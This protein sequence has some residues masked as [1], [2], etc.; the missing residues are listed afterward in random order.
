MLAKQNVSTLYNCHLS[1]LLTP[2]DEGP[3]VKGQRIR[4]QDIIDGEY[5]PKKLN[6]SWIGPDEFLYQNHWGEI[7]LLNMN[8]L[9]ERVL[10]SNTTVK[11]LAP[12]KFSISAD[13]RYLL[14]A[15]NVNKLFRHSFLAQYT[16]YDIVTS[17][18][19]PLTINSASEDWPY[20]LHAEFTPKGQ[21]IVLVYEYDIFY[22][23]SARA[24]Q[25]H[26]VT[27]NAIPGIVY[28][29]VPDWLYEEEILHTNKAIWLSTDGHLMLY[30]TFNDTLVQEQQFAW[31][32]TAN[33][34]I[35][36]YPQ[37]RSLRFDNAEMMGYSNLH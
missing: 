35:N 9:S 7:S 17:E 5:A 10:M 34:D 31:Y 26:R 16:V 28:N 33:G 2:P 3:R 4:L 30:T 11:T 23:P 21:A 15:Q 22:R 36:L 27:R 19:I 6:G 29:G 12:V 32:G 8:N 20:L 1:V 13:R 18:T 37:I 14:L 24:A 25:A